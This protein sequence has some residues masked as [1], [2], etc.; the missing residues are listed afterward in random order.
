MPPQS[1]NG[2]SP[3]RRREN[4][5]QRLPP[6]QEKVTSSPSPLRQSPRR[7]GSRKSFSQGELRSAYNAQTSNGQSKNSSDEYN[8]NLLD[9][10]VDQNSV[11][12]GSAANSASTP[13]SVYMPSSVALSRDNMSDLSGV[14]GGTNRGPSSQNIPGQ[15]FDPRALQKPWKQAYSLSNVPP[16]CNTNTNNEASSEGLGKRGDSRKNR[17]GDSEK[18]GT[19]IWVPQNDVVEIFDSLESTLGLDRFQIMGGKHNRIPIMILL[20]NPTKQSY[21]LMQIWVDRANDSIRDLV[22]VLQ[23]KLPVKWKQAYDGLFQVRGHRFTQLINIIRLVKYDIQPHEILIAKPW[24]T[25]AKVTIAFAGSAIKHLTQ[26]G[27]ITTDNND[28]SNTGRG[29]RSPRSQPKNEDAP[30][31]L[32]K[33]AQDRAY[34]PEGILSHHHAMQFITFSPPFEAS[35]DNDTG[36]SSRTGISDEDPIPELSSPHGNEKSISDSFDDPYSSLLGSNN[37]DQQNHSKK[38]L[39]SGMRGSTSSLTRRSSRSLAKRGDSRATAN[40]SGSYANLKSPTSSEG[41]LEGNEDES[42]CGDLL[43]KL[44]CFKKTSNSTGRRSNAKSLRETS[45]TSLSEDEEKEWLAYSMK[46]I[47]EDR[48]LAGGSIVSMSEPL[49]SQRRHGRNNK[50]FA[51]EC[52]R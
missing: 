27:V 11:S 48:S 15:I 29:G 4:G 8:N 30:L 45:L 20:M 47:V 38:S 51:S 35:I 49:L 12:G 50:T 6:R 43:A 16:E 9:S 31:L 18:S 40:Q 24:A 37:Y 28:P 2:V 26:I 39:M 22:Q 13:S 33:R 21:E 7:Y 25:T 17:K 3:V 10:S 36:H 44:N 23:H 5:N 1:Q 19:S 42:K 46:P 52:G 14:S 41:N 34:F 32:S